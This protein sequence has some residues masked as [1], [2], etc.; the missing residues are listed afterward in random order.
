MPIRTIIEICIHR[1]LGLAILL[2]EIVCTN[3]AGATQ[4]DQSLPMRQQ[5]ATQLGTRHVPISI[6]TRAVPAQIY[7]G[8]SVA[9]AQYG[10]IGANFGFSLGDPCEDTGRRKVPVHT[11]PAR[12]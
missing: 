12:M 4:N 11:G 7:S 8:R 1:V 10:A 5:T 3:H 6:A 9:V 2:N